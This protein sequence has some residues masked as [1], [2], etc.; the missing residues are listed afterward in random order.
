MVTGMVLSAQAIGE[1]DK[2][3]TILT[4]ENGK[5]S[6][7]A[8]GAKKPRSALVAATNPF[9][10]G[11]FEIFVG[12]SSMTVIRADI[13]NYFNE[14]STDLE[15]VYYG[16]YFLELADYYTRENNDDKEV[17]KLLYTTI[18]AL[19]H[20]GI[21]N[22][23]IKLVYEYKMMV[24]NGE[25]PGV[26]ECMVCGSKDDPA[27]FSFVNNGIICRE[28]SGSVRDFKALD[29]STIYA[30]QFITNSPV[31]K[32]YTFTV[33]DTVLHELERIVRHYIRQS[34]DIKLKSEEFLRDILEKPL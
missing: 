30:L 3:V 12:R 5:I 21:P 9:V 27:G 18:R 16:S 24:I 13:K 10:F 19:C 11:D 7:F 4:A 25:Y 14:V 29:T 2:R 31:E 15:S 17:L 22:K 32:L 20:K 23:L 6:A 26:F 8:K 28:C 34:V 1:T 33:N